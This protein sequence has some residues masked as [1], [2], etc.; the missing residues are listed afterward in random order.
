MAR[1][2]TGSLH[3]RTLADGTRVFRLRFNAGERRQIMTLHERVSCDCGC[4]GGWDERAARCELAETVARVRLGV[5]KRPSGAARARRA[6]SGT[7]FEDYARRW[8]QAKT[9]GVFGEIRASTAA[10][11]R[12]CIE[13]HLLPV[14]GDCL[15]EQIDRAQ[16]LRFK[17]RLVGDARELREAIEAGR[18]LR[19]E[20]G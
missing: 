5:W 3:S 15:V 19:D 12:W 13:R 1:T 16:C 2:N 18:D 14:F 6:G 4:G 8:L 17:A 9:D 20:R 7:D 11:Y 10:D